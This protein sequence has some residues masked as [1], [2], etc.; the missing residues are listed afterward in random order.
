MNKHLY[1]L[2]F[3]SLYIPDAGVIYIRWGMKTCP[4]AAD[5]V[6]SGIALIML[7]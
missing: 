6:Y 5:L 3:F 4:E 2:N 7:K 1:L